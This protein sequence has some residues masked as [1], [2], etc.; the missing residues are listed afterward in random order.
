MIFAP[1][2]ELQCV[3]TLELSTSF[4]NDLSNIFNVPRRV[5]GMFR[6]LILHR[7]GHLLPSFISECLARDTTD[8]V[9]ASVTRSFDYYITSIV[10]FIHEGFAT[11]PLAKHSMHPWRMDHCVL[12]EPLFVPCTM[13]TVQKRRT[14][15]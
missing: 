14:I 5:I 15:L 11:L 6:W 1:K 7:Q 8:I 10:S 9:K 12:T 2:E 13:R 3:Y 4:Q